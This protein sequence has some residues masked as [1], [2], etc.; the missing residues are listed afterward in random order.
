LESLGYEHADV[1]VMFA[2]WWRVVAEELLALNESGPGGIGHAGE[3]ETSLMMLIAPGLVDRTAA[4]PR[5]NLDTFPWGEA[6]LIRGAGATV[7]RRM[8][9]MT[10]NGAFG[11]PLAASVEKGRAI[12]DLV[13]D[14][15]AAMV[16]DFRNG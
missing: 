14:G 10:S 11:D 9:E 1:K 7:Y 12:T 8:R 4:Q 2:S 5:A 3:F 15:L 13:V 16:T 6:D